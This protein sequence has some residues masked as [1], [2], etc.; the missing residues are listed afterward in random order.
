MKCQALRMLN[1]NY[2][3]FAAL[4]SVTGDYLLVTH[5][6]EF[7]DIQKLQPAIDDKAYFL[8]FSK[9]FY[10]QHPDFTEQVWDTLA[11]LRETDL[12]TIIQR[13]LAADD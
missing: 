9:T 13:Y 2:I 10:Q 5:A 6:D 3:D 4:Q 8:L 7:L 12:P 1:A 11:Q